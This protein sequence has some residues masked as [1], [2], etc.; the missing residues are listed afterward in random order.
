MKV[1]LRRNVAKLGLIG[2]IVEVKDGYARNYLIPYHLAIAPSEANLKRVEAEKKT[3]LDE[4]ARLKAQLQAKAQVLEG[5]EFTIIAMANEE[6]H[7]YG[8]VGPAQVAEAAN[9]EGHSLDADM[10][11]LDEP[12]RMLGRVE[13]KVDFGEEIA[14]KIAVNILPPP[15]SAA[16]EAMARRAAGQAAPPAQ[17]APA[18]EE[19]TQAPP[20][21][22]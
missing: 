4:L 20:E 5:K 14:A 3:Y 8:S 6:G 7:L 22:E 16:A 21:S 2:E 13:V 11:A 18:V 12:I 19:A 10:V 17:P 15:G 1:L 9:K